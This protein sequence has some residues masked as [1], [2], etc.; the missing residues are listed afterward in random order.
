LPEP[1]PPSP[2][3]RRFTHDEWA[4]GS[5][6]RDS[7]MERCRRS[8]PHPVPTHSL[9]WLRQAAPSTVQPFA[10]AIPDVRWHLRAVEPRTTSGEA[11]TWR[12]CKTSSTPTIRH[13]IVETPA[14][15]VPAYGRRNSV[16]FSYRSSFDAV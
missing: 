2:R 1:S 13:D 6:H 11:R 10:D 14:G 16:Q 7:G 5:R 8:E 9:R 4:D 3:I 12:W 15:E